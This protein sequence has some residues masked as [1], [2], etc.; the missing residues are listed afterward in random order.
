M[1]TAVPDISG[2]AKG[3]EA[4]R[5]RVA[6][7]VSSALEE[8]GF[9]VLRGHDVKSETIATVR[10][11]AWRFFDLPLDEK[12][13]ARKRIQG[14]WCGYVTADDENLSYMQN[15][16]S[17][18]DLKKFFGFGRFDYG[19]EPYYRQTFAEVAFP[20]NI[21]PEQPVGFTGV[22]KQF[23]WEMEALTEQV[24][25]VFE[26]ALGLDQGY[27]RDKFDH[28]ASTVR[29]LNYPNQID[30]PIPGQLRCAA[31]YDF[32][33]FTLLAVDD[34]PGGLQVQ[35]RAGSWVDVPSA[36]GGIVLNIGDLMAGWTNDRWRSGL[37]RV[38]NPPRD[39]HGS[40]R[41]LSLAYFVNP[42]YD[43]MVECLPTCQDTGHPP[44]YAPI[45]AGEHRLQ[46]ILTATSNLPTSHAAK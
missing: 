3:D 35:S 36:P 13:R 42:N 12:T 1:T 19:D 5:T 44:L 43:A 10:E 38:V 41:R 32:S 9:L 11:L 17:P 33:A 45:S 16:D 34:A 22:A 46:K 8:I 30:D 21:W 4:S 14:A 20:P 2:F 26:K 27:F 29:F 23:Y 24:L 37:H 40:T 39:I 28:H 18:P 7:A 6:T 31:H 25:R 15:E